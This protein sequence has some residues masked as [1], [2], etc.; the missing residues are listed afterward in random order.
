[1][2]DHAARAREILDAAVE[3]ADAI[4]QMLNE[5]L[6]GD[7][8]DQLAEIEARGRKAD[9]RLASVDRMHVAAQVHATL[10]LVEQQRAANLISYAS[11]TYPG[12]Q[13]F[14]RMSFMAGE[15]PESDSRIHDEIV[16]LLS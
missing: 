2:M 10:A 15:D 7:P 8:R 12:G 4:S 13:G 11:A 16:R 1:M 5:P 14:R 9:M 6:S 3:S